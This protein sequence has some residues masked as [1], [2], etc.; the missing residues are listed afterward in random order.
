MKLV[1][2]IC[3]AASILT[4]M[5]AQSYA[6][7]VEYSLR[8][9]M[10]NFTDFYTVRV[11]G[12]L[13]AQGNHS[14]GYLKLHQGLVPGKNE[15]SV[16][17]ETF[18]DGSKAEFSIHKGCKGGIPK[19]RPLAKMK[20]TGEAEKTVSFRQQ[21]INSVVYPGAK[22]SDGTGL[23]DAINRLQTAVLNRDS[24]TIFAMHEPL[25]ATMK[26][27]G[28]PMD[29]VTKHARSVIKAGEITVHD[30]LTIT[31]RMNGAVWEVL[32]PNDAPPVSIHQEVENGYKTWHSG[33]L[34][35]FVNGQWA[36]LE[37]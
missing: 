6:C 13:A 12:V 29:F 22:P 18:K 37:P 2:V 20:F 31:P 16:L 24:K 30:K 34:W 32:G 35:I 10:P 33:S 26:A 9:K 11:N 19:G 21:A 25:L 1:K 28:A 23:K 17:Y 5:A 8:Y 15:V 4:G 7:E 3:T 36:I 14:S 27:D